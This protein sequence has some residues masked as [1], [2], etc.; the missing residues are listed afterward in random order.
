MIKNKGYIKLAVML[1]SFCILYF[2]TLLW[3]NISGGVEHFSFFASYIGLP[4]FCIL[5]GV[6][7][8]VYSKN[9][10]IPAL[11]LLPF[12]LIISGLLL[13]YDQKQ[14]ILI[15]LIFIAVLPLVSFGITK[16]FSKALSPQKL[17][18]LKLVFSYLLLAIMIFSLIA[19]LQI[20]EYIAA[21]HYE[22]PYV[23]LSVGYIIL[24]IPVTAIIIGIVSYECTRQFFWPLVA[25]V[26]SS[27]FTWILFGDNIVGSLI[28]TLILTF[29]YF[30]GVSAMWGIVTLT[31]VILGNNKVKSSL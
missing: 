18:I 5:Y 15:K 19:G 27:I 29:L 28:C 3:D 17:K 24:F 25:F 1:L 11:F 14:N 4:I 30:I 6:E 20:S 26:P 9:G 22:K 21:P 31:E 16:L 8:A 10:G 7:S 13:I 12:A 23:S 2:A